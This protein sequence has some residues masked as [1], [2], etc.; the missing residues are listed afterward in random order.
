MDLLETLFAVQ[1]DD[2]KEDVLDTEDVADEVSILRSIVQVVLL[3]S[4]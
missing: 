1:D 2:L 4:L 3:S